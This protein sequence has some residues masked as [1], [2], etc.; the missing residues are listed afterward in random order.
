MEFKIYKI[1][2]Y[3]IAIIVIITITADLELRDSALCLKLSDEQSS[4]NTAVSAQSL[5]TR[6]LHVMLMTNSTSASLSTSV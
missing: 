2:D 1:I 3:N 4:P 6:A 5:F